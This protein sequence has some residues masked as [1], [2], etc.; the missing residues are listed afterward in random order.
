[1]AEDS[2]HRYSNDAE[3]ANK[4]VYDSF[5]W[6]QPFAAHGLYLSVVRVKLQDTNLYYN[7]ISPPNSQSVIIRP[8]GYERVYLPLC[9]VADT[10]FHIQG[11]ELSATY[12]SATH[13]TQQIVDTSHK[14][15]RC[16]VY[17]HTGWYDDL[18]SSVPYV[19]EC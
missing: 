7:D 1:M 13:D 17:I 12:L 14:I 3:R 5:K 2:K 6:K 9:K 10:P 18:A 4:D 16:S 11:D 15:K 8:L 19:M